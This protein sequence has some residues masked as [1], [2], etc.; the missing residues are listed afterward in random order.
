MAVAAGE[1]ET[2]IDG[3]YI[4]KFDNRV[5]SATPE[6]SLLNTPFNP[7][8]LRLR[9]RVQYQIGPFSAAAFLNYTSSYED[10]RGT[11]PV[12]VASWT[13]VDMNVGY[14]CRNDCGF[15]QHTTVLAGVTN[16]ANRAP[17]YLVNAL[18]YG[19]NFDGTNANALGRFIYLQLSTK[20]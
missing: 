18:G 4:L 10:N 12:P 17:P 14:T 20:W 15:L 19:V 3:T 8:D 6:A 2:G 13:T 9:P 1:F 5:T 11:T 7:I 16:I